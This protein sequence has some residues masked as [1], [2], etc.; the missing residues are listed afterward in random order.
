M[1]RE[2]PA[3]ARATPVG[4]IAR[5]LSTSHLPGL[6]VLE[7][8]GT[9]AGIV[10]ERDL[11]VRHA[12]V[13][14]PLY[15]TILDGLVPFRGER[16]FEQE[17]RRVLATRAEDLMSA[18]ETVIAP[19]ADVD[20]AATLMVDKRVNPLPVVEHG[21]LVGLLTRSHIVG[22]ITVEEYTAP[23]GGQ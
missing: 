7:P 1:L 6:P 3:I 11:I 17:V 10:T 8:D 18:V 20:D 22:L 13:H 14:L 19:D 12:H 21:M 5:L 9:L 2:P 16:T 4:E 23:P 15:L